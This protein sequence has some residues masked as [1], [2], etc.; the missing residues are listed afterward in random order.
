MRHAEGASPSSLQS[1]WQV[2]ASPAAD[3]GV[4]NDDGE[5]LVRGSEWP[6]CFVELSLHYYI[7]GSFIALG[8]PIIFSLFTI[9]EY[10]KDI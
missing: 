9:Y 7:L 10:I 4:Q 6:G 8:R 5:S 3:S 2:E 1:R